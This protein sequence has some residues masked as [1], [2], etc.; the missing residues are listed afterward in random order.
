M[1]EEDRKTGKQD[2]VDNESARKRNAAKLTAGHTLLNKV[3]PPQHHHLLPTEREPRSERWP[4]N[5][6][7]LATSDNSYLAIIHA[8]AKG[9]GRL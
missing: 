2:A 1:E 6:T 5:L 3:V 8:D 4:S 7:K 9:W